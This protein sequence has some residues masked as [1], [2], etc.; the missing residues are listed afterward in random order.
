MY[1][2]EN[3]RLRNKLVLL[4]IFPV[5]G[6]LYFSVNGVLE[7]YRLTGEMSSLQNLS[8]L[9]VR[10]SAL[11]HE[12]QKERG[13]TAGFLGS[14]G[15]TFGSEIKGQRAETDRK[16]IVLREFLKGFDSNRF[17]NEFTRNLNDGLNLLD[18]IEGKREAVSGLNISA[19]EAIGYYTNMNAQ[20]LDVI[21]Y[22]ARLSS[23][24]EITIVSTAY[25]NFLLGKERAGIERAV[26][27]NTFAADKFL[28]GMFNRFSSLVTEQDVY[29]RSFLSFA[30]N[31]QKD[32]F[33]K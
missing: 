16:I 32:F 8:A 28:P 1:F 26:M 17:G 10:I 13:A 24:A 31:D 11:V 30:S 19:N 9:A 15:A 12:T 6:L 5:L 2:L 29:T 33:Q 3:V 25:V 7:K 20:F 23:K 22:I 14:G 4:L 18:T 21:A 27:S